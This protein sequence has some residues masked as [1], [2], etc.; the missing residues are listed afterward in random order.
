M[1]D[2][3]GQVAVVTGGTS[4]IG[5][6]IA[7]AFGRAGA[8][9]MVAA[10]SAECKPGGYDERP[11]TAVVELLRAEGREARFCRT[12]MTMAFEVER[13]AAETVATFG[14]IDIWINNAGAM[15]MPRGFCEYSED[16]LDALLG[17][18]TK[19]T[20]LGMQVAARQMLRQGGSGS[21]INVLSMAGLRAHSNQSIYNMSKAAAVMAT[22][23]AALEL[24][25][26]GIRVNAVC[27][28]LVKTAASRLM[29]ELPGFADFFRSVTTL[30]E[31]V[32]AEQ[33]AQAA[34]F[35]ASEGAATMT[36]VTLPIDSGE[37]LGPPAVELPA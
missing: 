32:L 25:S 9:V 3:A 36:G 11:E 34:L 7:L 23:C 13:L 14:R 31:P 10:R 5:R 4:G 21:I 24:G 16:E 20:W 33:V 37:G 18:N 19:G 30:G 2:L 12:D 29:I 35:L 27:P 8:Q 6:A 28:T 15:P 17:I 1:V 22:K 26:K